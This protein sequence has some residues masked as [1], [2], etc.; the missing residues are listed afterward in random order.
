MA[1]TSV[2]QKEA[3]EIYNKCYMII[4]EHGEGL[5]EEV[6]ISSLAKRFSH[7]IIMTLIDY[8]SSDWHFLIDVDKCLDNVK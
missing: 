4:M 1:Q 3:Q 5:A 2:H 6:V 7:E 8:G